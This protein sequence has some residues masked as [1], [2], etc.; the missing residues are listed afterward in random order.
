MR[1]SR[2]DWSLPEDNSKFELGEGSNFQPSLSHFDFKVLLYQEILEASKGTTC[3]V[4]SSTIS[5]F[6][7][8]LPAVFLCEKKLALEMF[9]SEDKP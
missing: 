4:D 6:Y 5:S 8:Q 3:N 9:H 1:S 7:S 2:S